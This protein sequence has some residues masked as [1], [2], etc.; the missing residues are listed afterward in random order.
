MRGTRLIA[1]GCC[2]ALTLAACSGGKKHDGATASPTTVPASATTTR[3]PT[4][5]VARTTTTQLFPT[6]SL[7]CATPPAPAKPLTN[8]APAVHSVFLTK[9]SH[10]S[11]Q[12]NDHVIFS[13]TSKSPDPPRY[14]VSYVSGPFTSIES[15]QP[16]AIRGQAFVNV[17]LSPAYSFDPESGT[18]SYTG[19]KRIDGAGA[20]HVTEIVETGD[21]EG[22]MTWVI[23]LATK[24]PFTVQATGSP[25]TQLVVTIA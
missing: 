10:L 22:V 19:P 21:S 16:I 18:P 15:D 24:R 5:T 20:N 6:T 23:G 1:V 9:V 3:L 7:P 13:L 11:D 2:L 14:T 4:T 25:Q 17:R 8:P 12:C